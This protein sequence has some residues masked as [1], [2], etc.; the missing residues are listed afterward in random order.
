MRQQGCCTL[1]VDESGRVLDRL[2]GLEKVIPPEALQQALMPTGRINPRACKLTHE[3]MMGVLLGM[4]LLT[5]LSIRQVFKHSRRLRPR[6]R[7][8]CRSS[9][10]E[11]RQRLGVEP[12]RHLHKH[13][14]RPLA[15]PDTPGAFFRGLRRMAFDGTVLDAPDSEANAI[16]F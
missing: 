1:P 15:T 14:V 3:V 7:T 11:A 10:C 6:E 13:V 12:L 16:A 8:P 4:G 5:H 9:L 2:A